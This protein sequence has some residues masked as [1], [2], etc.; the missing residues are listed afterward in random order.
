MSC[1]S[2]ISE[3]LSRKFYGAYNKKMVKLRKMRMRMMLAVV[4]EASKHEFFYIRFLL[5]ILQKRDTPA[6]PKSS[7]ADDDE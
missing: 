7:K 2:L 1:W 4:N 5:L 6:I 3:R